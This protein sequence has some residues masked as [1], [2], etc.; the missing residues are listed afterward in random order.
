MYRKTTSWPRT[1]IVSQ[2]AASNGF[3]LPDA[4]GRGMFSGGQC[5]KTSSSSKN[6]FHIVGHVRHEGMRANLLFWTQKM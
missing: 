5:E 1:K 3:G 2:W 6:Q 4:R